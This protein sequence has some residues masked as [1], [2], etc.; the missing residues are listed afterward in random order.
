LKTEIEYI[1]SVKQVHCRLEISGEPAEL[2]GDRETLLFRIIQEAIGN[3]LKH[4]RATEIIIG[5]A[6][7]AGRLRA[8]ISDNGIGF[9]TRDIN[10]QTKTGISITNMELRA[11]LLGGNLEILSQP[12]HGTTISLSL[13]INIDQPNL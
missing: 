5:L 2:S 6:Y 13:D 3:A 7:E 9:N 8:S 11:R 1:N 4:A 12:Q 10:D